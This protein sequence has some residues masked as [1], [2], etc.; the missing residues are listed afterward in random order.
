VKFDCVD[1]FG[2]S[3]NFPCNLGPKVSKANLLSWCES[4]AST[5]IYFRAYMIA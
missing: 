3:D 5:L 4:F 1:K 2:L